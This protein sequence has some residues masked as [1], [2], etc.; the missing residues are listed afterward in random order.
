MTNE[1]LKAA[2]AATP[3]LSGTSVFLESLDPK[4]LAGLI[5]ILA[6]DDIPAALDYAH[7]EALS[8]SRAPWMPAA[9]LIAKCLD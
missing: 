7:G 4:A 6:D 1:K 8:G 9:R 3:R 5:L 2:W